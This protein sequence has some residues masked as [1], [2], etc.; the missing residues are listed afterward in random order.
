MR[1]PNPVCTQ[2]HTP[3]RGSLHDEGLVDAKEHEQEDGWPEGVV[4]IITCDHPDLGGCHDVVDLQKA[5]GWPGFG[6]EL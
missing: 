1:K 5:A 3:P 4:E 6:Q 2:P